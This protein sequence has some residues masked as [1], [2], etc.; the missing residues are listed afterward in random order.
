MEYE[1][2]EKEERLQFLEEMFESTELKVTESYNYPTIMEDLSNVVLFHIKEVTFEGEEKSPRREAFENVIGMIQNEGVNFIYLILG[3]KKGV[4][5]YF[6]L[7][8][9]SKYDG[10]LPMPIDEMGNNL[11]KSAIRGNFRGS[12]IEEVKPEEM[13]E[14]FNRMQVN[15]E[16]KNLTRKYASVIGTPGINESEDKKSFQGVD[17]LVDVM[18]GD[19]FGLCILAKPLSKR[20]IKKIEDDLYQIYN[21]LSIFS[22]IS[23]QEGENLSK[24]T[25]ISKGTSDS[26]SSGENTTK[27]TNYSKTIGTS[28]NTGTSESKTAGSTKGTNYSESQT[29]GKN[30]GKSEGTNTGKSTQKG[31]STTEEKNSRGKTT[32]TSDSGTES[33]GTTFSE[34]IGTSSSKGTSTGYSNSENMSKTKGTNTSTGSSQ[35]K[36]AGT[37]ETTGTNTSTTKGT[38]NSVSESSTTGSSQNISKDI[39][40]KKAA[41]YVKYIDEMLLPIIDYG[42]SKGLYLTT[43]FIFANKNSQLE[44]LGNTIK[45]LYSG[46]KGNKN[47]LDFEILENND[48]KI[49]YFKNFQIPECVSYDDENALTLKSHFVENDEVSLGNWYSPNELGLIAGLPEKEVVGLALN[50]EVEFGLNAKAPE[51]GE[52]L[53]SLG[54]LVQS[55][56]KIDVEV[57]LEK[58]AL[59]KHI[60]ITGVTGTG[61]TT[62]CQKLLL[63]SELPFLV[64]EPAKTEYRILMNNPKTED[65]LI[66]TLGNDKVAPFRLNPFEFFEGES[67]TSRV[68]MLKAAM[69]ASFDMEAAIPQII[70][71][72]M[73]SCYEDYGWNIDTDENE[74]FENPYDEGVYS[75]PTLEDLLNK[76]ETEV[77]KHNFDDRL[78]KDYIGSITARLQGLLVGSKGQMLNSRRSI[79]FRELIEKKVVLEIE[80]I[81][82]GTEKSLVMGFILTNLC[83]ALRAKY[84]KD[85]HFKHITLI[86]EAHR[87]LSK[88]APGDSLNKKNSVETFADMLAEVRKYGESLI[89]ADQIPNKMTPEVLKN[90]NTKIVHKIFAE[91][92]K[93]AIGNTISL[94]K[95]QKDFLSSLPT[96]R[97]I[98][99]SQSWTKAVQVQIERMTDTTSDENID[100][101]RLKNRVEDFYIENYK[102]G[103]FIG[104]KY[105]K[106]TKE[107]FRLCRE[108]S[109]NKEFVKIFKAVFEEN[110]NS[111]NDFERVVKLLND[112][113][114]FDDIREILVNENETI[115]D[116]KSIENKF[117]EYYNIFSDNLYKTI[118]VKYYRGLKMPES[119]KD[120]LKK[121]KKILKE[122]II[123]MFNQG[124]FTFEEIDKGYFRKHIQ[125]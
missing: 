112:K 48:K 104:T 42:K 68:D 9:E 28:E 120:T 109:T 54:Y 46:K 22:K 4:S 1:V 10:E 25:S 71:S 8:K 44:K 105:E 89:I 124:N 111:F 116:I 31:T 107:Q 72:A 58:S 11:L 93:E 55:G 117:R 18:Q 30:W 27:G 66:F 21:S 76:V 103:I 79:D 59:N 36:T 61:K 91:D 52:E 84:N 29:E 56:N 16:N 102:K 20:A 92:D 100:E 122:S 39:I 12:K 17:R 70:E 94:S 119:S 45:S 69:E 95:E 106:I 85:K 32:G 90:T 63:E 43:T 113:K 34:N 49:E 78:K 121:V 60:F 87:L 5:F 13:L 115:D 81:K 108:F 50:E 14:I 114:F 6:G 74:K 23:L 40:N 19:D 125:R 110:I 80:G 73:Y 3:D 82:N 88:Y 26:V 53:I 65:I 7:V 2:I 101:D 51:K 38:N 99:F 97:A 37:S 15:S 77:T 96:G 35:S 64:I 67:I 118:Y 24:G 83:E 57:S 62:T 41:D 33:S 98:V 75:F 123:K 47:P 86:E